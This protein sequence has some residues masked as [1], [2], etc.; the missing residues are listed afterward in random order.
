MAEKAKTV[1]ERFGFKDPSLTTPEHDRMLLW[2]NENWVN[3]LSQL[4]LISTSAK[5]F[6]LY[7]PCSNCTWKKGENICKPEHEPL[8]GTRC[9][10]INEYQM[11]LDGFK[12]DKFFDTLKQLCDGEIEYPIMGYNDYNIGF[13][14]FFVNIS[15]IDKFFRHCLISKRIVRG[16]DTFLFEIKPTI[17]S[18]GETIRQ[19]QFYRSHKQ[20]AYIIVTKTKGLKNIFHQQN[21]Y[22]YE[23]ED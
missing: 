22:V 12:E 8:N 5:P 1:I 3:V 9:E 6:I 20:G 16:S 23:Y 18:I 4:N 15:K 21:I 19:I 10:V 7:T 13:I 2:L 11:L 14:D 17:D